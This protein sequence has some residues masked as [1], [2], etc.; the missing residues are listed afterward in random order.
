MD[1]LKRET[2]KELD[3]FFATLTSSVQK[4]ITDCNESV[5]T[6][7]G[8]KE[9]WQKIKGKSEILHFVTYIQCL[10]HT[11]KADSILHEK[12]AKKDIT[13]SFQPNTTIE[14]TLSNL[15]GLGKILSD[16]KQQ[17]GRNITTDEQPTQAEPNAEKHSSSNSEQANTTHP[18]SVGNDPDQ[19]LH[20]ISS[21]SK[22][23]NKTH[24]TSIVNNTD[25]MFHPLSSSSTDSCNGN[26]SSDVN[27]SDSESSLSSLPD[28]TNEEGD[29]NMLN[30]VSATKA[31]HM[32]EYPVTLRSDKQVCGISG[33]CETAKGE[34]V[35]TDQRNNKVKLL[36]PN[37]KVVTHYD[38]PS[39][40]LSMCSIDSWL[41]AV[42]VHI[43]EV[44]FIRVKKSLFRRL[45]HNRTLKFQHECIG[46]AHH[47]DSLYITSGSALYCYTLDGV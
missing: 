35:I 45:V 26:Q 9:D 23:P 43:N 4:D 2:I 25:M 17:T 3:N 14:K 19:V 30:Q 16:V 1:H 44:H 46:I 39:T 42:A 5:Q 24:P 13:F 15:S 21:S 47:N 22:Q 12:L 41:V 29:V 38:L 33:I 31:I 18:T 36:D 8:L 40:P 27:K 37:F 6:M 11:I 28:H 32:M 10:N 7:K 34:L 20:T